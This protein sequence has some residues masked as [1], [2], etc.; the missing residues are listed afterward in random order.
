MDG[1]ARSS[2]QTKTLR[3][4]VRVGVSVLIVVA[5]LTKANPAEFVRALAD[6]DIGWLAIAVVLLPLATFVRVVSFMVLVNRQDRILT[7]RQ[8]AYLTL[9][10]AGVGLFL[11]V[12]VGDLV[13]ARLASQAHGASEDMMTATILDKLTSLASVAAMGV[14][15]AVMTRDLGLATVAVVIMV[16]SSLP[17]AFPRI[18]PWRLALRVVMPRQNIDEERL[19][20]AIRTS[21]PLLTGV[22]AISTFGWTVSYVLIYA[23]CRALHVHVS[24]EYVFATAPFMTLA[25]LLPI[26]LGGIGVGQATLSALLAR[27][28]VPLGLAVRVSLLQ[29]GLF[30]LP[31]LAGLL[32]FAIRPLQPSSPKQDVDVTLAAASTDAPAA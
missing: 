7:L 31:P 24:A 8:A 21:A 2:G 28:G 18:V 15:G 4:L 6:A 16:V 12:A 5:L 27:A 23:L 1:S 9:I 17:F 29:L 19:S 14:V 25:G 10:G 26:S 22:L 30:I 3:R 11:P 13:K 20:A 32:L